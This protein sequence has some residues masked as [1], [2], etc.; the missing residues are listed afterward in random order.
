MCWP[1]DGYNG[2]RQDPDLR[3]AAA[4][5]LEAGRCA[6]LARLAIVARRSADRVTVIFDGAPTLTMDRARDVAAVLF[7]RLS[8]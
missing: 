5:C 7:R 3:G 8:A 1:I 4:G 6:L 2:I